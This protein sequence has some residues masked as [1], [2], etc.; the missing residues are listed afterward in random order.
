MSMSGYNMYKSY[1][2]PPTEVVSKLKADTDKGLNCCV[3]SPAGNIVATGGDDFYLRLWDVNTYS[4]ENKAF[5]P[6]LCPISAVAW[7]AMGSMI[8]VAGTDQQ[9]GLVRTRPTIGLV[10]KFSG[11]SECITALNFNRSGKQVISGSSDRT[12]RVWDTTTGDMI[13]QV[14]CMSTITCMNVN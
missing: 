9:I 14:P 8:A 10:K 11:H 1:C 4:S 7:N 12:V 5:K 13:K 6:F 3:F 2:E